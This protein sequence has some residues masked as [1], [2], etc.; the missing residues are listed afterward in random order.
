MKYKIWYLKPNEDLSERHAYQQFTI[1]IFQALVNH[2][3]NELLKL[4]NCK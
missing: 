1:C 3:W 4:L 2:W